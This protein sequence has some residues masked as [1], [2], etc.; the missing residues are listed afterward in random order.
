VDEVACAEGPGVFHCV[1]TYVVTGGTGRFAGATGSGTFD[2]HV[3]FNP[4]GSGT[5]QA[6][7]A[8]NVSVGS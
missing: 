7:Y 2:G 5:F 1:G 8:G 4:D 6:T 3:T